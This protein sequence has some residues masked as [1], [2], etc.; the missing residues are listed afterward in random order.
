VGVGLG[1]LAGVIIGSTGLHGTGSM[2]ILY[3]PLLVIVGSE[4]VGGGGSVVQGTG[5][6]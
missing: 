1:S 6:A 5:S 2:L 3:F 4:L